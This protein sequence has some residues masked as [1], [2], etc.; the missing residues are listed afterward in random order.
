MMAE[1][2]GLSAKPEKVTAAANAEGQQTLKD[3]VEKAAVDTTSRKEYSEPQPW[4]L[5]LS[6]ATEL[7]IIKN[8]EGV[9]KRVRLAALFD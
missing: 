3:A 9:M 2:G 7:A 6:T 1:E 5:P 8:G 4:S